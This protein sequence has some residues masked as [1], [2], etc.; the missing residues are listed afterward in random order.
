MRAPLFLSTGLDGRFGDFSTRLLSL[1][2]G[3]DDSDSNGLSICG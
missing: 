3:L 1:N 2:N